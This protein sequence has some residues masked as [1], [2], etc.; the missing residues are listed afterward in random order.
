MQVHS[1]HSPPASAV[2]VTGAHHLRGTQAPF[3]MSRSPPRSRQ[4]RR[5]QHSQRR[6]VPRTQLPALGARRGCRAAAHLQRHRHGALRQVGGR[7]GGWNRGWTWAPRSGRLPLPA[8]SAA[9]KVLSTAAQQRAMKLCHRLSSSRYP[10]SRVSQQAQTAAC[11]TAA[12]ATTPAG[13]RW[14]TPCCG[15]GCSTRPW[16][17]AVSASTCQSSWRWGTCPA[18][19]GSLALLA[20]QTRV[21]AAMLTALAATGSAPTPGTHAACQQSPRLA[22]AP[23]GRCTCRQVLIAVADSVRYLHGLGIVH[24]DIK[25]VR[26]CTRW[27]AGRSHTTASLSTGSRSLKPHCLVDAS[28]RA[29]PATPPP[30]HPLDHSPRPTHRTTSFSSLTPPSRPA[31]H[32]RCAP[33]QR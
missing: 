26:G 10:P 7:A 28:V 5:R 2:C 3:P 1:P 9:A 23:V 20:K 25:L 11:L 24:G 14:Q 19:G 21:P 16:A 31:S 13:A 8:P 12:S 17:T 33:K 18:R 29:R 15:S 6:L 30:T 22:H 32:P 27:M 4:Q